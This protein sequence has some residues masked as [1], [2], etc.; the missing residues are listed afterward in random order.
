MSDLDDVD[1]DKLPLHIRNKLAQLQVSLET[2]LVIVWTPSFVY[3]T[4]LSLFTAFSWSCPK[5]RV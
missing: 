2:L 4:N 5:V 3:L 1:V